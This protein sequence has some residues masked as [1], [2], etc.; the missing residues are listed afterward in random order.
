M[1]VFD[2]YLFWVGALSFKLPPVQ[3]IVLAVIQLS[4]DK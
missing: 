4:N 1:C 2:L 3:I